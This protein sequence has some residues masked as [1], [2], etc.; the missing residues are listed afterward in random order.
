M[1]DQFPS[2]LLSLSF[3][4]KKWKNSFRAVVFQQREQK[5]V[6]CTLVFL[7]YRYSQVTLMA[8]NP[9][10][11]A[12]DVRDTGSILGLGRSFGEE[13]DHQL[14]YSCLENFMERGAW[15]ATVH[16]GSQRVRH[17]WVQTYPHKHPHPHTHANWIQ[18]SIHNNAGYF[19]VNRRNL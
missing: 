1:T 16:G 15:Q 12:G 5:T 6:F 18:H 9:P 19:T 11:K 4:L 13:S 8:K 3:E 14:Q 7:K 10:A 17:N 2:G